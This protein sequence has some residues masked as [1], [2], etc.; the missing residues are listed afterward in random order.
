MRGK[1]CD[2]VCRNDTFHV[3]A[4]LA[5]D[6]YLWIVREI[7]SM[8]MFSYYPPL[9]CSDDGRVLIDESNS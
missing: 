9:K 6:R 2:C 3:S 1:T 4:M 7:L 8:M 5:M